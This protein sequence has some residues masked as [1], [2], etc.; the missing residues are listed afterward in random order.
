MRSEECFKGLTS[1]EATEY[2]HLLLYMLSE[3]TPNDMERKWVLEVYSALMARAK[4][5]A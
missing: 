2:A 4:W 3:V 1:K 5:E